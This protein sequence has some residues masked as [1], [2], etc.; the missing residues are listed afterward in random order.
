MLQRVLKARELGERSNASRQR[1]AGMSFAG[2]KPK[3]GVDEADAG[4]MEGFRF[5][6][7][8]LKTSDPLRW[9]RGN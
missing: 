8:N 1:S 6:E 9:D 2:D 7:I 4:A 5:D 3:M